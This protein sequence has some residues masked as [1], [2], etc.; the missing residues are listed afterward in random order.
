MIVVNSFGGGATTVFI[1]HFNKHG[2]D[3]PTK[4][5]DLWRSTSEKTGYKNPYG[6][7]VQNLAYVFKHSQ[8]PPPIKFLKEN[9]SSASINRAVYLFSDP[10]DAVIS[11]FARRLK[12]VPPPGGIGALDR[13]WAL[14]HAHNLGGCWESVSPDWDLAD[15]LLAG[16]ELFCLKAH[17]HNWT[18]A[19]RDYPIL[20][21]RYETLWDHLEIIHKFM[22]LGDQ[23]EVLKSFPKRKKRFSKLDNLKPEYQ[24]KLYKMYGKLRN[25]INDFPD[26]S[27]VI[28]GTHAIGAPKGKKHR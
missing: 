12:V 9:G 19:R 26:I 25:K 10:I 17:F 24:E 27:A 23:P 3:I 11:F 13:Y 5:K 1:N 15:Y 21:V 28:G 6:F 14:K 22:G 2:L 20:L 16:E 4:G 7:N 8:S 18:Q